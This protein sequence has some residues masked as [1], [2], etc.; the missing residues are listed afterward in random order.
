MNR[1][2]RTWFRHLNL[3]LLALLS[4]G[5]ICLPV[6]AIDLRVVPSAAGG[7]ESAGSVDVVLQLERV[8]GDGPDI[9]ELDLVYTTR[10]TGSGTPEEASEVTD[11][12]LIAA[13][14]A[15]LLLPAGIDLVEQTVAIPVFDDAIAEIT[16]FFEAA[17]AGFTPTNCSTNVVT[18]AAPAR[19]PIFDDDPGTLGVDVDAATVTV[20]ET[21]G[22]V[23]VGVTLT[24]IASV[25]PPIDVRVTFTTVDGTALAGADYSA[26]SGTLAFNENQLTQTVTIPITDDALAEGTEGFQ[27]QLTGAMAN[28]AFDG[29]PLAVGIGNATTNLLITDDEPIGGTVQFSTAA[30]ATT[31]DVAAV[32]LTVSRGGSGQGAASVDFATTDGTALAGSD[33]TATSGTLSWADGDVTDRTISIE[34]LADTEEE[35]DETFVV[36]LSNATGSIALG[37]NPNTTVTIGASDTRRSITSIANLTPNQRSLAVWFD[38]TCPRF[39]SLSALTTEQQD[40]REICRGV[41][42]DDTADIDVRRTLDAI[43]PDELF[44]ASFNALRLTAVQHSN[45]SQ[46]INALRSGASGLDLAGLRLEIDGQVISGNVLQEMFDGLLGLGASDDDATWGKWGGFV[47]G[48]FATGDKD[49]TENES[50]FDFDLYGVTAGID[51]RIKQNFIVGAAVGYGAVDTDYLSGGGGLDVDSWNG[52]AFLTYFTEDTFFFDALVSYGSNDYDSVRHIVFSNVN[53]AIDRRARGT[54]D[55]RQY[56]AGFGTGWDFNRR[57][58]TFGP[59]FGGNYFDVKVEEFN[60]TGAAGLDIA[61]A[62]QQTRSLT[63]SAGG[64]LSYAI[65]TDWGVL[66]PNARLDW[67]H[68]FEDNQETLSYQFINDPFIGD[69][70]DPSPIIELQTDRPDTDYFIVSVGLSAQFIYGVGGFISYQ[71]YTGYDDVTIDEVSVGIRWEKTF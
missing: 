29:T 47:D 42:D 50:G 41:R 71:T 39:E 67:V 18:I 46:R 63:L 48:R 69:P 31:E 8:A 37:A 25:T 12:Q 16:E 40:L 2:R 64:H 17:I 43:N 6:H 15:S 20:D 19:I 34:L 62:E 57:S 51:Y 66:V 65:N 9:C 54:T 36:Q 30:V 24:G 14:S 32:Q 59:H 56:S 10:E 45:L 7:T 22:S 21:A 1:T 3:K 60:E 44:V 26:T 28:F 61:I 70:L 5:A 68:E 49:S 11:F 35:G 52:S 13:G 33:Y 53:G 38:D 23:S 27:L 4:M 55:G 58:W